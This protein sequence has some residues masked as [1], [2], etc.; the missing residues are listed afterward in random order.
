MGIGHVCCNNTAG[1]ILLLYYATLVYYSMIRS[2]HSRKHQSPW[3]Q[4]MYVLLY[5][6][7]L[8]PGADSPL[9]SVPCS[10]IARYCVAAPGTNNTP[11]AR[12]RI[13]TPVSVGIPIATNSPRR[14][15]PVCALCGFGVRFPRF[16]AALLFICWQK[17]IP[18]LLVCTMPPIVQSGRVVSSIVTAARNSCLETSF[19]AVYFSLC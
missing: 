1:C 12:Q 6:V 15:A 13:H 8:I 4:S 9:N 3:S 11:A 5:S 2:T 10:T 19:L 18:A 7:P 16:L 14:N 17:G